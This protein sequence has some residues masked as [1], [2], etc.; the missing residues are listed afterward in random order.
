SRL[1]SNQIGFNQINADSEKRV[2][3]L[4]NE[5][6]MQYEADRHNDIA[7]KPSLSDMTKKGIE[8]LDNNKRG[9]FLHVE[10]GRIDHGHHAGSAYNAL[11]DTIEFARAV[12]TAVESV[13]MK[14]TLIIVTADHSHVFTIAGY[15]KRGNPILGQVVSVGQNTPALA[16]DGYPYTTLGYTNGRGFQD[17]GNETDADEAYGQPINAGARVDLTGVDTESSGFH[18]EAMVPLSSE[19]HAGEDVVIY[20]KGPGAH[21]VS[22]TNEQNVIFHIM[23]R[24]AKLDKKA[25][26]KLK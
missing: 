17:L 3:A 1:L 6:H 9:F 23:N 13:D 5:S 10:S 4:F 22:G 15:P 24:T 14:E 8:I 18:Q 12:K 26:I 2:F 25:A 19:T 16:E 11:T 7:G 20:G 21:L